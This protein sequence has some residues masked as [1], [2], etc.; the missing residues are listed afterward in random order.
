MFRRIFP[1][2]FDNDYRGYRL[3]VWLLVPIVLVKLIMSVNIFVNTRDII[4]GPDAIPLDAFSAV[5][6]AVVV[7]CFRSW[8]IA[9]FVLA[10]LGLLAVV[11]YRAMV[12]LMYLALTVDNVARV[13]LFLADRFARGHAGE[14][15]LGL[16]INIVLAAA[17]LIGFAL[18]LG[19]TDKAEGA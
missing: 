15:S 19:K 8:T 6:A 10:A 17:L 3:A 13:A 2:Q 7:Q 12:P 1:S 9:N 4:R 18:S 16:M 11:R 14:P 5:A